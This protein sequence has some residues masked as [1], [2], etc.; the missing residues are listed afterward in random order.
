MD[1]LVLDRRPGADVKVEVHTAETQST[2]RRA[3]KRK[4]VASEEDDAG[5][6]TT[7]RSGRTTTCTSEVSFR[8]A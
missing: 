6:L 1:T 3:A 4:V 5:K 2:A 8:A 7:T